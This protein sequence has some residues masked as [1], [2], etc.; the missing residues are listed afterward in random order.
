MNFRLTGL[1]VLI[2][3]AL[4]AAVYFF[5][6]RRDK[7]EDTTSTGSGAPVALFDLKADDVTRLKVT[8]NTGKTVEVTKDGGAW[9][10]V[11]PSQEP[12]DAT[13]VDS[14][15]RQVAEAKAS[16]KIEAQDVDKAAFELDK[17][18]TIITL[19]TASGDK[20][21]NVG[22]QT[23]DKGSYYVQKTDDP[24]AYLLNGLAVTAAT[25][26]VSRPPTQPTPTPALTL[27][28]GDATATPTAAQVTPTP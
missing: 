13:R 9:R 19:G 7:T 16:R 24:A 4:V 18:A 12:A 21:L 15:V 20:T 8:D 10:L 25:G 6:V 5:D 2:A 11:A 1:L 3:I 22:G 26:L 17:P 14:V 27:L 28:P 23:P